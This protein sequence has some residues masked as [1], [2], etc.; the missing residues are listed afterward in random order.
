[1]NETGSTNIETEKLGKGAKGRSES[2][3]PFRKLGLSLSIESA[4]NHIGYVS[5]TQIQKK[6]IPRAVRGFNIV[7]SSFGKR[8]R[9]RERLRERE[10]ERVRERERI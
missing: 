2:S 9:E 10:R 4:V 8:E 7:G 6:V 3:S 1:M 5:P